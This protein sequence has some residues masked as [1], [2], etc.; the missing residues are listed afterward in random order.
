MIGRLLGLPVRLLVLFYQSVVLALTQIWANKLRSLLTTVGIVIGVA[1]VT[2]VIAAMSGLRGYVLD[3]FE[4]FGISK[5][6]IGP[7]WVNTGRFKD[8]PWHRFVFQPPMFDGM[9]REVPSIK[10]F[11]R[12]MSNN[13]TVA[14]GGQVVEDVEITGIEPAWHSI[15]GRY[16]SMGRPILMSD[17]DNSLPVCLI[18]S[19]IQR[20]LGL[21]KDPTN[22]SLVIGSRRFAIVGMIE[23]PKNAAGFSTREDDTEIFVPF[24]TLYRQSGQL[25]FMRVVA[26]LKTPDLAADAE[27]ELNFYMRKARGLRLDDPN[28]FRVFMVQNQLQQFEGVSRVSI[29]VATAVVGVSLVVGGVGIMNIML[30]S[31]SE[32]TREIGLRKAVGAKPSVILIQFLI[33]AVTLCLV[34]G[35]I[36]LA[37]GFGMTELLK[38]VPGLGALNKAFVPMWAVGLAFGFSATVG[39]VF[40]VFPAI[41]AARLDPIEALRHE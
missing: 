22:Q 16:V 33:E 40:G 19:S 7:T 34:G 32:R 9:L 1:S 5:V 35:L 12:V 29:L 15:E 28:N 39:L 36:G 24:N 23:D 20:R 8:Q 2:S 3:A 41:K 26:V 4:T 25:P 11:S 6:Y 30:V 38:M 37:L 21:N 31:V 10:N 17:N 14:F 27:A 13:E 18:S